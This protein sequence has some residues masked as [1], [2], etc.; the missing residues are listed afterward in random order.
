MQQLCV[1]KWNGGR[2]ELKQESRKMEVEKVSFCFAF[3]LTYSS[4]HAL[5][6]YKPSICYNFIKFI[7][8][9]SKI[10]TLITLHHF[11]VSSN[12]LYIFF[13]FFKLL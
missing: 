11:L 4:Q 12:S 8:H 5:H 1:Y 9:T 2:L 10:N 13:F 6:A 3:I 7:I